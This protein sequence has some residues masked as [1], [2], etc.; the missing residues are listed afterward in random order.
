MHIR[1]GTVERV[2]ESGLDAACQ[3]VPES[4]VMSPTDSCLPHLDT[5]VQ[6]RQAWRPFWSVVALVVTL[7]LAQRLIAQVTNLRPPLGALVDVGQR[8]MHIH[9][10]GSGNPTVVLESGA[11]SLP[12]TGR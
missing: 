9:C 5:N 2:L 12:S 4:S 3:R 7:V 8:K 11:S 1:E 10:V 6:Q